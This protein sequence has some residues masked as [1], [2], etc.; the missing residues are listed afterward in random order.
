MDPHAAAAGRENQR[1]QGLDGIRTPTPF[2]YCDACL[3]LRCHVGLAELTAILH[4]L[5]A[6]LM[7]R[8]RAC[9]GCGRT[10]ELSALREGSSRLDPDGGRAGLVAGHGVCKNGH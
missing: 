6:L 2:A 4:E 10:L 5:D 7:R 9:Y 3:A 8:R 1:R